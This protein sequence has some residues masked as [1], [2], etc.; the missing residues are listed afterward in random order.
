MDIITDEKLCGMTV[1][2]VLQ[3]ELRYS[4][5]MI[6]KLKFSD[7]GILV[8][9]SFVTVR[10]ELKR[11]DVL[12]L[13]VEDKAEDVSPYTVPSP[14]HI[15]IIY[16]DEW[17]TAVN[18]PHA[19]PSHPS[20]GHKT[21]TVSNALAYRYRDK[22]YVFRPVNRLDRDTSGCMLTANSKAAS[23]IMYKSM[24][25]G[26][27]KKYYVAVTDGFPDI[28][29]GTL[30]SYLKREEGS[31]IKRAVTTADDVEGK[32]AVTEFRVLWRE[33][34]HGVLLLSPVTGRTHQIRLQL[35]D[36]GCPVTGDDMYGCPSSHILRQALH[37]F[38][39]KLPHPNSGEAL[40]LTAPLKD[41]MTNL[42][43]AVFSDS[44]RVLDKILKTAQLL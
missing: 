24:V 3:K 10:Y 39:T 1:R 23:Y 6:K 43:R 27:I 18:K 16:E 38:V 13:A 34:S 20:L 11:G 4:S 19:M 17:L 41:D 9:G 44:D 31:I 35:A 26:D 36:F 30:R 25:D 8:N 40:K 14:I 42:I 12:S 28:D 32:I 7:G 37:S 5:N 21:D 22:N 33:G 29:E 15:D 2:E